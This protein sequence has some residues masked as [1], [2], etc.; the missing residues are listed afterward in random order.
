M[1]DFRSSL[2]LENERDVYLINDLLFNDISEADDVNKRDSAEDSDTEGEDH[3]SEREEN[4]ESGQS[5]YH[6]DDDGE[7][8]NSLRVEKRP[9]LSHEGS[10]VGEAQ[11]VEVQVAE[12]LQQTISQQGTNSSELH[13]PANGVQPVVAQGSQIPENQ[14]QVQHHI[15]NDNMY[16]VA[17]FG[18][19]A[20]IKWYFRPLEQNRRTQRHNI[21]RRLPG[22]KGQARQSKTVLECW[23]NFFT[24]NIFN[25]IVHCTNLYIEKV[26]EK[27]SRLRDAKTT[28]IVEIK[29]CIGLLYILGT[30]KSNRQN[31]EEV[32]DSNGFGIEKCRMVMNLR[33]FK[34][35]LRCLR[36]DDYTTRPQRRSLDNL[37]AVRDIFEMF[38][39]NCQQS[40]SLGQD[41]TIDEK[42]EAFRGRCRF[43]QYIPSKPAKYGVKIFALCDARTFYTSNLEVYCG[44]QPNGPFKK[45]N[46]SVDVVKRLAEPLYGTGRNITADNWFSSVSLADDLRSNNLSYV[47][48]IKKNRKGIPTELKEIKDRAEGSSLFAF[49][50]RSTLV[51]F[52][53]KK[54]KNVLLI[55][56]LHYDD[57]IDD[58]TSKPDIV[59]HYNK[60]KSGVDCVDK[61]C[62]SYNVARN[63]R[64]WPM[65]V[66][67]SMLNVAG[68]N[69]QVVSIG[70]NIKTKHRRLFLR[71]L[72]DDLV[73]DHLRTRS[74]SIQR[75]MPLDLQTSLK[76]FRTEQPV[77]QETGEK[78][79]LEK[80][81]RCEPCKLLKKT[82]LTSTVCSNCKYAI[83]GDHTVPICVA[84]HPKMKPSSRD[85]SSTSDDE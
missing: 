15:S 59:I 24:E 29:A 30:S 72:A 17:K 43:R 16:Y 40:Y 10:S 26:Q 34:F 67:F 5:D 7:E 23:S 71:Q 66:F 85:E 45:S 77:V 63:T 73:F 55:S 52:V 27:F 38:V 28:N 14:H 81:K 47:G 84:C 32:W 58:E 83:C 19:D 6:G 2:D 3:V 18:K 36:F 20:E 22:V 42:L 44:K 31:L 9:R 74:E 12:T 8:S 51:S 60:T 37:A 35:L 1:A 48:T 79:K 76:K 53:P 78:S 70:N 11:T 54:N 56:T 75:G 49:G 65:V 68:I 39:E 46:S 61:L 82:R 25:T 50:E 80:R 13:G 69:A 57:S 62:A 21:L 33:R 4:S 41:V 64:R